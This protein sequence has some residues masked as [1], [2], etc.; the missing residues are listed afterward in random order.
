MLMGLYAPPPRTVKPPPQKKSNQ[1]KKLQNSKPQPGENNPSKHKKSNQINT[2]TICTGKPERG[3]APPRPRR[4]D[5]S[6]TQDQR[7]P[8]RFRHPNVA[9]G[10]HRG[11][12]LVAF[13]GHCPPHALPRHGQGR[14][15]GRIAPAPRLPAR[16]PPL[17]R[18]PSASR[19]DWPAGPEVGRG[20]LCRRLPVRTPQSVGERL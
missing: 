3:R 5:P 12:H 9:P 18:P 14:R 15:T 10:G 16:P 8:A 13:S 20:R 11:R 1:T 19:P 2:L 7:I 17:R 4:R 6:K